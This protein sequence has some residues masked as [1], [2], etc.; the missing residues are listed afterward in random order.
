MSRKHTHTFTKLITAVVL[1]IIITTSCTTKNTNHH[2][3]FDDPQ[4]V[5]ILNEMTLEE[6]VGQMTQITLEV[7]V[8]KDA[9]SN[10]I[11]PIVIDT[12][13][14]KT[15]LLDYQV[16]SVLNTGGA[17][18]SLET[19]HGV[20]SIIQEITLNETRHKIPMLYGIDAIHGAN[21]TQ[22]STLFPQQL[23]QAA[24]FNPDVVEVGAKVC[25]YE[26][27]A[28]ATPWTF[29]PVLGMGRNP[30]WPRFWET[31][32]EDTYLATE[33]GYVM[34]K[35]FQGD[36]LSDT[37]HVAAC[38]KHYMG[39]SNPRTGKDRTPAWIP[40]RELRQYYLPPFKA[41]VD[42]GVLT[43]MICSGEI[44]GT[45]V[46]ADKVI[47][48]DILKD[49]LGY[50]GFS[51]SDWQDIIYLHTRH[52]VAATM[53]EA[54]K[55]S[56]NAGID[57][58]MVPFKYEEFFDLLVDLVKSGEV[59][60]DR[61]NDA[62]A[63][64]L[65]VK[66][67]LGLWET[68]VTHYKGYEKF[69]SAEFQQ[70]SLDAA[71][72]TIILLENNNNTLPL[73]SSKKIFVTGPTANTMTSLNGGWSYVWQGTAADEFAEVEHT[74]LEALQEQFTNVSYEPG[75]DFDNEINIA[76]AKRKA[77][78]ADAI[79]LC[80]G[81]PSYCE[82]PGN[83][84][85]LN[86]TRAQENLAKAMAETG[87]P[88]ILVLLEGRPRIISQFADD[89]DAIVL[90]NLPGNKG[91][92]AIA[93]VLA[94]KVNPSGKLPYTYPRFSNHLVTYDHKG[95]QNQDKTNDLPEFDPQFEFGHG[96]SYTTFSY[97]NLSLN[98]SEIA[99]DETLKVTVDVANTGAIT[100][101]ESVLMYLTDH[102]AT[103]TPEVKRLRGF[104]KITLK[105]GEK[106]TVSFE[107][108]KEDFTFINN[109]MEE[110]A[111]SGTFSVTI[112]Q[113]KKDFTWNE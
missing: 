72:E 81:E 80:L 26:T 24:S 85:D 79:V 15:A 64:I 52:K 54:V 108:S 16:G 45:P 99:G 40:E 66:K 62:V 17:A 22:G 3:A 91:G 65:Y 109:D 112:G 102:Y 7:I 67:E 6:K 34:T 98:K 46:H 60:E 47:L 74:V 103:I 4:I 8:K 110:V 39:Y 5:S 13:A 38:M 29:S 31:F 76:A 69:A 71:R 14:L 100:G 44:N 92:I 61:I 36:D 12:A 90:A 105:P 49:E 25:A 35:G 18:N 73:K 1:F 41:S 86:I 70:M 113:L 88:V 111:E 84:E 19:W 77:A 97:N 106:Q 57:M 23:A 104:N 20:I 48:T 21:Y 28:S 11:R 55:M 93:E 42:A 58:S 30:V 101:K 32:G 10:I 2:P 89:M 51:V 78:S 53:R 43:A 37:L 94:G 75:V 59:S 9:D 95:T 63:R 56:I 82:T 107:L 68:P 96:L 50:K 87:K 27:R 83:I 33:L